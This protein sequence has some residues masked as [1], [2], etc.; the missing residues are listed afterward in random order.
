MQIFF[1]SSSS[2]WRWEW[3]REM[4]NS[5]LFLLLFIFHTPRRESEEED[6]SIPPA[7]ICVCFP[8]ICRYT[9]CR[10]KRSHPRCLFLI[11][12]SP[13]ASPDEEKESFMCSLIYIL[14]SVAALCA[15]KKQPSFF[16]PYLF[17]F[18]PSQLFLFVF[19]NNA[20][21]AVF[22]LAHLLLSLRALLRCSILIS[23]ST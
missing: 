12:I 10:E 3:R 19:S 1:L 14:S 13:F 21:A 15:F 6:G 18:G 9:W 2:S 20:A 5:F 4:Q 16:I 17:F 22:A 7:N 11:F 8:L 23:S